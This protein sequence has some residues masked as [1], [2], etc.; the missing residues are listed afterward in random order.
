ME[1]A[2]FVN[3]QKQDLEA[4]LTSIVEKALSKHQVPA[5]TTTEFVIEP[6][7]YYA[8]KD[9]RLHKLFGVNG[10]KQPERSIIAS[11]R[12]VGIDP[13]KRGGK[14]SVIFGS[15]INDYFA[16]VSVKQNEF[17]RPN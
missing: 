8:V 9:E 4:F 14:G 11:L 12:S 5:T 17:S 6:Q 13:I 10:A 3:G 7:H 16:R 1:V 15:Q 2:L